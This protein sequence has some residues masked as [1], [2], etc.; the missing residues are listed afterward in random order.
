MRGKGLQ[1]SLG[2]KTCPPSGI[3]ILR[4]SVLERGDRRRRFVRTSNT[5]SPFVL[6]PGLDYGRQTACP[7]SRQW[8][9]AP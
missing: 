4:A 5:P 2:A 7:L 6:D 1:D 9:R 8:H 3:I